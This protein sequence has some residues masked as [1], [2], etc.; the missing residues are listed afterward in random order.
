MTVVLGERPVLMPLSPSHIPCWL[1]RDGTRF[2]MLRTSTWD[3]CTCVRTCVDFIVVTNISEVRFTFFVRV[4]LTVAARVYMALCARRPKSQVMF[5]LGICSFVEL[6][7][8]PS[9]PATYTNMIANGINWDVVLS[10]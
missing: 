7:A 2:I 8:V 10:M 6:S 5:T 3:R 4:D 9:L 1:A